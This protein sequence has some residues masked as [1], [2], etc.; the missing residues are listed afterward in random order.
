M[1]RARPPV[2]RDVAGARAGGHA[3]QQ[4]VAERL[5]D[6]DAARPLVHAARGG[7]VGGEQPALPARHRHARAVRPADD[8]EVVHQPARARQPEAERAGG[9]YAVAQRGLEVG[10]AGPC[11]VDRDRDPAPAG[12]HGRRQLDPP[13]AGVLDRVARDLGHRGGDVLRLDARE[14]AALRLLARRPCRRGDV[15]VAREPHDAARAHPPG[16]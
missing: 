13:A 11:V 2:A 10:D 9:R 15:E 3:Q 14:P 7:D 5:R 16:R 6:R 12:A 1:P 4:P 8:L